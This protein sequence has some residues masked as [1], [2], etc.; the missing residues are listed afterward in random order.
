MEGSMRKLGIALP[1]VLA[2]S[3]LLGS[4]ASANIPVGAGTYAV[5][6]N[7]TTG[8]AYVGADCS[9]GGSL[10]VIDTATDA[11]V[12]TIT[13]VSTPT[14]IAI[15]EER[16][17]IFA[18]HFTG[19]VSVI[20]GNTN[21]VVTVL[22]PGG[23]GVAVDPVRDRL[24]ATLGPGGMAV[25][26]LNT[27]VQIGPI[28]SH[29][30]N[31]WG[32]AV[33]P[34]TDRIYLAI[35]GG[36]VSVLDGETFTEHAVPPIPLGLGE[37]RFGITVDIARNLVYVPRYASAGRILVINGASNT[38][39]GV[40]GAGSFPTALA[41]DAAHGRLYSADRNSG[42]VSVLST[43]GAL[44]FLST[45]AV[46]GT[47]TGV[48]VPTLG[49][50]RLYVTNLSGD[51]TV[52]PLNAPPSVISATIA[53]TSPDTDDVLTVTV[54]AQDPDGDPLTYSYQWTKG[55]ADIAGATGATL[56]LGVSG[57]GD[58]GDQIAVRVTAS[59]RSATSAPL[60][61]A[62]VTVVNSAP[63]VISATI[64]PTSPDTDD[65][66]TVTV[67]AQDLDG[68]PLT[69]SYQWTKGGIDI[70]GATGATLDLGVSGNGDH[71]DQI[72][73]RVTA[74]DGSATSNPLT[75]ASVTVV[76]SAPS[77]ISATIAPTSPDTDDVLTVTVVAQDPDGD[78]LTYSYQWTK[79]GAEITD[80]IGA[81]LDLGV[82]GNGDRGDQIAVRVTARDGSS[83][84]APLT[85]ASVTVIN[86]PPAMTSATIAPTSPDTD[87]VLTATG[88][89]LDL[90]GD[91]LTY[92]YQWTKNGAEIT[93][94]I[95]ATLD[96]GVS[97][98]GDRGDQIAVRV[99]ARDGSSTSVPLTSA[100]VTV[101]NSAPSAS[102]TLTPVEPSHKALLTANVAVSDA[103]LDTVTL[104]YVWRV[105]GE[106][107]RTFTTTATTDQFDLSL[108]HNGSP[109][110][111][112]TL[113]VTPNDSFIDGAAVTAT[114]TVLPG[115]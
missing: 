59:D 32:V 65:V 53:P 100:A 23:L 66:L 9:C 70:T 86:T 90:D 10:V 46:G 103:D 62:A 58:H 108:A 40:A 79:N 112:I 3:A 8:L 34:V 50:S 30:V 6:I 68:D 5:A 27:L 102:V 91:P 75:S 54:V 28:V 92:S 20:D 55:G 45:I 36:A 106:V 64:A 89:A 60:T 1:A 61:S 87:D 52:I 15:D 96:L 113:T 72:A 63:S 107:R 33:N 21:T 13:T 12:T 24:Y 110:D 7:H 85:S 29:D 38:I 78:P 95:G 18:A 83:T 57:N 19:G 4:P 98:N 41:L 73:V 37:G 56:D 101:V 25:Y 84:S 49:P 111:T 22:T 11:V 67:V 31:W 105:Q 39:A 81:T 35:L 109:H 17:Q 97:G 104:T 48:A 88:L 114:A 42:T 2:L 82:S 26:D 115:N 43:Q 51:V 69:Y 76:N 16:N 94:A 74:S 99:T 71:G 14:Q 93:D 44:T 47:P 80:A 77:V